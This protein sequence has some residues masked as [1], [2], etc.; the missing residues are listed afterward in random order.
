MQDTY[1]ALSI[2]AQ[3]STRDLAAILSPFRGFG[4]FL[5]GL[6]PGGNATD[7]RNPVDDVTGLMLAA[8]VYLKLRE[9]TPY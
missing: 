6:L 1:I 5:A 3:V 8:R 4:E 7:A 2:S 9:F